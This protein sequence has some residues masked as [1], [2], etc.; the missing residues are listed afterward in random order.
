MVVRVFEYDDNED[1]DDNFGSI[2]GHERCFYL[3]NKLHWCVMHLIFK[4][5]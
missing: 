3:I 2:T 4:K 5:N 1:A